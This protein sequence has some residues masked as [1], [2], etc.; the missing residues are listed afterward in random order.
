MLL[1]G[2]CSYVAYGVVSLSS[3]QK[4]VLSVS[5]L[6]QRGGLFVAT[7]L[8]GSLL[9]WVMVRRAQGLEQTSR[10]VEG[11]L[12]ERFP[13]LLRMWPLLVTILVLLYFATM[14]VVT[15]GFTTPTSGDAILAGSLIG[16][17]L[18][19]CGVQFWVMRK[20]P[21]GTVITVQTVDVL[22]GILPF[23]I[24]ITN[25]IR[26]LVTLEKGNFAEID[27]SVWEGNWI[28]IVE[29]TL[30]SWILV[31]FSQNLVVLP[32]V[33]RDSRFPSFAAITVILAIPLLGLF[34]YPSLMLDAESFIAL[35][36]EVCAEML[37]K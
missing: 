3:H 36:Q 14:T 34:A 9:Y 4:T 27:K 37:V 33:G 7:I 11:Y 23:V 21:D 17:S 20:K 10:H 18:I 28:A 24:Y 30:I 13:I 19:V 8:A 15:V 31:L 6:G 16:L 12:G 5:G 22:F 29:V 35:L 26:Y 2:I 25:G 1:A 32:S